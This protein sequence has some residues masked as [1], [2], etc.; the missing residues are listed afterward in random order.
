MVDQVFVLVNQVM[1]FILEAFFLG[2][3][4]FG[5][6]KWVLMLMTYI[7]KELMRLLSY[8][9]ALKSLK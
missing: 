2:V 7:F 4:A 1:L 9:Q 3:S 6:P 5:P 8:E